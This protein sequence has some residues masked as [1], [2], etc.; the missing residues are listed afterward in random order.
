MQVDEL[1]PFLRENQ[2]TLIRKI[3]EGKYKPNSV[4]RVEIPKETKGEYRQ[5][6]IPTAVDRVIQQ[7]I[8]QELLPIYGSNSQRTVLDSDQEEEHTML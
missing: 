3:R 8:A 2:R 1:L 6:G 4:R 5:L 7:A